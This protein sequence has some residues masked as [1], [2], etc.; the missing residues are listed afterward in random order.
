MYFTYNWG[1][2]GFFVF[3]LVAKPCIWAQSGSLTPAF[4]PELERLLPTFTPTSDMPIPGP[5]V[6]ADVQTKMRAQ[7]LTDSLA[8]IN[9][10]LKYL[11]GY[12]IQLYS[13]TSKE[14]LDAIKERIYRKMPN[15]DVYTTYKQPTYKLKLGDYTDRLEAYRIINKVLKYEFPGAIVVQENIVLKK[16]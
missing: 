7:Y 8:E 5:S 4:D 15:A 14:E 12:R 6:K 3:L 1:Y 11:P 2:F 16:K 10:K 9:K 13:G